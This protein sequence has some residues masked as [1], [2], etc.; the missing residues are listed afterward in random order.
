[1]TTDAPD[2]PIKPQVIDLQAEDITVEDE[3]KPSPA[4]PP[5][6]AARNRRTT[7]ALIAVAALAGAIGGGWLY[8][9]VLASYLPSS[10]MTA[11][12]DRVDALEAQVRTLTDQLG[13]MASASGQLKDQFGSL[14]S[15]VKSAAEKATGAA[16]KSAALEARIAAIETAAKSASAELAE[17]KSLIAAGAGA[18]APGDNS[19]ALAL[20]AKRLD[21]LEKQPISKPSEP[22][23]ASANLSQSLSDLKAK[24]AAGAAYRAEVDRIA[25]MTPA[26]AGLDTLM[27]RADAGL[28]NAAGLAAELAAIIS[29][30]PKPAAATPEADS[31]YLSNFWNAMG[32]IV[33]IRDI[34]QTDWQNLAAESAALAEGGDLAQAIG[35]IDSAEGTKPMPLAQWRDRA[36]ARIALEAALEETANAVLRQIAAMGAAP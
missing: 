2:S 21:A 16:D 17:I 31:G 26:A 13:G 23:A 36:A 18:A 12:R 11:T 6:P 3:A 33:R 10:E 25:A 34:G 30:L 9:D 28:P 5:P 1:M 24:I 8:K 14:E 7:I 27:A 35:K 32:D 22:F 15:Q 4:T 19:G 20:L 29:Q